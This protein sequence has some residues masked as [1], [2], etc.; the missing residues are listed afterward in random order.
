MIIPPTTQPLCLTVVD[1]TKDLCITIPTLEGLQL[2]LVKFHRE[3]RKLS[4][5][6]RWYSS[7]CPLSL[8]ICCYPALMVS[9]PKI[10][11]QCHV[12]SYLLYVIPRG[13]VLVILSCIGLD[14]G[15]DESLL[16]IQGRVG[17]LTHL[18]R[19]NIGFLCIKIL[20]TSL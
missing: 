10:S 3:V 19:L 17:L 20:I 9:L 7:S 4:Y 16:L 2:A 1:A 12:L 14:V 8:R 15:H 18:S 5:E 11:L 13:L 6:F